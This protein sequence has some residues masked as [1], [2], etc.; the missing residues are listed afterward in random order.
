MTDASLSLRELL[1]YSTAE[2]LRWRD[3]L[4]TQPAEILELP[5]GTGRT[6]TVRQLIHHIVVVE[7][8]YADRIRNEPVTTYEDIPSESIEALFGAFADA[9]RRLDEWVMNASDADLARQLEFTTLSAGT[10]V[11]SS[12][13]IVVHA[14]LHGIRH[15]A[16]IAMV[17]RQHGHPTDWFHDILMSDA[18]P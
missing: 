18:L 2:R 13:K 12:R 17:V 6:A 1:D 8:R 5:A 3:W 11:A 7:R 10:R 14:L 9:R 16:Q 4:A 15:W